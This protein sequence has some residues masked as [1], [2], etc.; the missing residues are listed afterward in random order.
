MEWYRKAADQGHAAAQLNLGL[1]YESG[2][3]VARD[4]AEAL[5]WMR[6]SADGG[7]AAAQHHLGVR[8]HR[9]SLRARQTDSREHRIEAYKWLY[10]AAAQG[11]RGSAAAC[12]RVTISMSRD[13]VFQG[14]QRVNSFV[15]RG[16]ETFK[17]PPA[18]AGE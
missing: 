10:L 13:E 18:P 8:C 14:N 11:H 6:K 9:V 5:S 16:A 4:D 15:A 2:R 12:E 17:V 7:N 3:G 1:M